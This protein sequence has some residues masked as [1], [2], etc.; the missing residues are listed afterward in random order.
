MPPFYSIGL[1]EINNPW[2]NGNNNGEGEG[3]RLQILA[4]LMETLISNKLF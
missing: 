4:P 2:A 3:R 1:N